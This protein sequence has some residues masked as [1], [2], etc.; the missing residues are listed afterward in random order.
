[1]S[2][3]AARRFALVGSPNSGKTTLF[4][5]LTGLR[6]KVANYPGVT[7]DHVEG[8][9]KINDDCA[10]VLIDLPGTY[11]L[12]PLSP[13]EEV[14]LRVLDGSMP[15][16]EPPD[17]VVVVADATT[18]GRSLQLVGEVLA[19]GQPT[20]LILTMIDEM[21]ARKG[22]VRLH[23]LQK[24]LG[25]PV[26]GVVGNRG[27]GLDDVRHL[28]SAPDSW[29]QTPH[30]IPQ[31]VEARFEWVDS[32]YQDAVNEPQEND[33]TTDRIDKVL[34]HP[35]A[36]IGVFLLIMFL[37]FQV[38]FVVAA[39]LQGLF[40]GVV[41][42]FGVWLGG[43]LAPGLLSSLL[44]DG[45]I[46]GVGGVVVFIPQI[47]LLLLMV[48]VLETTGYMSRAAFVIDRVLGWA[49]LEG[50]SFI[51]LLSSYAC[52]VP[53]IMAT[54]AIPDPR[55]RLATILVAPFMT[56][57]ARLPV[58]TLLIA[59]F[60][61]STRVAGVFSLQGLVL[62]GLY[63]LGSVSALVAAA[64][65][66]RGLLRGKT[67]PFYME[68]PPYRRPTV[69]VV[70]NQVWRGV[71]SFMK[72]AGTVILA[73][74]VILWVLLSFPK[75]DA[76]EAI[77]SDEAAA[78]AY[79]LEHSYAASVGKAIEPAIAPLGFDWKIGIGLIA[80]VA[81]REVIVATLGQIYAFSGG[82][83]ELEGLGMRMA[84]EKTSTG[85]SVYSL[86]TVLS[87]LVFFVYSLLCISTIAV[88]RRET[89]SWK[90][91]AVAFGYMLA[92]AYVGSFITFHVA[93]AMMS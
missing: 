48:S 36:G 92:V 72:K 5:A 8:E 9:A 44:I 43:V 78:S 1:M 79:Q 6:Q 37:F 65:F 84:A 38:V 27:I 47:A 60:I 35:V 25:I 88:I 20:V 57:S 32:I 4:N 7:V 76:P 90:W 93:T 23:R 16:C 41:A 39:P 12:A 86:P 62:F 13:D 64:I 51:A 82:E 22:A 80:S 73:A 81:A 28:L 42:S 14:T 3:T 55:S 52:A 31:E 74:S 17:G 45:V 24:S 21:K 34:L 2:T 29:E 70:W 71:R 91:P 85:A 46:A 59:A 19:L 83:D 58:Y 18:L 40:E 26:V 15:D 11:S 66:K 63:L 49:G 50:R 67:Y 33:T 56:C 54:R 68:L 75:V 61:P 10:V 77:A 53:G 89:A 87:L 69:K 30:E